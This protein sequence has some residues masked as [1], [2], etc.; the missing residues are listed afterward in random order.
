MIPRATSS[1][2]VIPPK[3][4]NR[5]AL[6]FGLLKITSTDAAIASA[7]APPPASRK[8]AGAPPAWATT[9]SVDMT[10]P[11]AVAEDAD[12]AVE[13]DVGQPAL[14]R[15][16]LLRVGAAGVVERRVVGMAEAGVVVERDLRV[17]A[18][19]RGGRA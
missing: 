3:T 16:E 15:H 5:T 7:F 2:R 1:Q 12:V 6:T 17:Q 18:Q 4:L 13:L 14:A 11:G 19:R 9:S 10:R 8:F